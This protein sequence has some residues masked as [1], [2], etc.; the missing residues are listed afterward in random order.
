[1]I[2]FDL[3]LRSWLWLSISDVI[4]S[5]TRDR[6]HVS[7]LMIVCRLWNC[8]WSYCSQNKSLASSSS[9]TISCIGCVLCLK[10]V[11]FDLWIYSFCTVSA[12]IHVWA[13]SVRYI[14]M[15]LSSLCSAYHE[16]NSIICEII[17]CVICKVVISCCTISSIQSMCCGSII[18]K[19]VLLI[20]RSISILENTS[21]CINGANNDIKIWVW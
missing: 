6:C 11:K 5:L 19:C 3:M 16:Y 21:S 4:F 8:T 10:S 12:C 15:I 14:S 18:N 13:K 9:S 1:M 7:F 2:V 20:I 17:W